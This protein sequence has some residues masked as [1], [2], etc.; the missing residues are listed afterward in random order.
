MGRRIP[1]GAGG[2]LSLRLRLL[3]AAAGIVAVSLLLSGVLTW[4]L[5]RNLELQAAQDQVDRSAQ[6]AAARVRHE[7]CAIRPLVRTNAGACTAAIGQDDAIDFSNRMSNLASTL[8]TQRLILLNQQRVVVFDSGSVDTVGQTIPVAKSPQTFDGQMVLLGAQAITPS[9]D[10]LRA[11]FVV[12]AFPQSLVTGA[13]AGELV[14]R[15]LEAGG[16]ALLLAIVLVLLVSLSLTRPLRKLALA[17]EDVAA[18]NYSRRVDI[19]GSDEIGT[20]GSAFDRM[21]EAVERARG[22]QREFLT[23]VSHELKTPL[24]SIIGF[25]QALVDGSIKTED[26]RARAATVV[27]EESERVLRMAQ[28]L[29]DLAR[30]ESGS[31]SLHITAVD[32]GGHLEQ[33]LA[34]VR[35]RADARELKVGLDLPAGLPPVAADPERLHQI[36]DNLIDNAVKYAPEGSTVSA[37]AHLAGGSVE[38][39]VANPAGPHRPDPDRMFERFYRAD[40][41][42]SAAAGGV[43]LGLAISRE[44]ATAMSGRLWADIDPSGMLRVHLMLPA[45]K[46][47]RTAQAPGEPPQAGKEELGSG[48][49]TESQPGRS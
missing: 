7:E 47:A 20:L 4:V 23:N 15:L 22:I 10:P 3:A 9:R 28:E 1:P 17:A 6:L 40:P 8:G 24:T 39:V 11:N 14:P 48:L 49:V 19:R 35:P 16:A 30:V 12:I 5:V 42:R 29:L 45:A 2:Q 25:S 27:H 32:L 41:S 44:L 26:E 13:A 36:L 31:I 18:G 34:V 21:A 43:G 33:A 46:V 38:A 37:S